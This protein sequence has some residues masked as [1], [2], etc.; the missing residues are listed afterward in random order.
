MSEIDTWM[1]KE[2]RQQGIFFQHI[3]DCTYDII[4]VNDSIN[5]IVIVGKKRIK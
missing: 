2:K 1:N 5:D 3:R 4:I